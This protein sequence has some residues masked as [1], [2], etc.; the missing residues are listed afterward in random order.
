MHV[1]MDHV[2]MYA[3]TTCMRSVMEVLMG[4][5]AT[6]GLAHLSNMIIG[7]WVSCIFAPQMALP[8]KVM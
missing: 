4:K 7:S 2:C 1:C 5:Q 8:S 6:P 3:W